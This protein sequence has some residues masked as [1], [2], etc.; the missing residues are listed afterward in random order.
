MFDAK[1]PSATADGGPARR[2][3]SLLRQR[4]GLGR[5]AVRFG[6][7]GALNTLWAVIVLTLAHERFGLDLWTASLAGWAVGMLNGFVLN[8][9]WTFSGP[10]RDKP[11]VQL[12][13]HLA[14]NGAGYLVF[15]GLVNLLTPL[16]GV[17]LAGMV[18]VPLV[19]VLSFFGSRLFVFRRPSP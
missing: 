18:A 7:T 14:L 13:K 6:V 17:S 2:L 11:A 1:D 9:Y 12:A 16:A 3:L 19:V 5:E 15:G 8:K 4:R 10:Q